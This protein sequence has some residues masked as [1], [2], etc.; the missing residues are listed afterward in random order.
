MPRVLLR[1]HAL[2]DHLVAE[3]RA[4]CIPELHSLLESLPLSLFGCLQSSCV[5]LRVAIF[6]ISAKFSKTGPAML[7]KMC[8]TNLHRAGDVRR[9][10]KVT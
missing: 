6:S 8:C 1:L 7:A 10:D 5:S 3:S 4:F 9:N 2:Q